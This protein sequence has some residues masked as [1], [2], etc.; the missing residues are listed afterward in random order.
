[1]KFLTNYS[2]CDLK[3]NKCRIIT[4]KSSVFLNQYYKNFGTYDS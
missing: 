3:K 4:P 2:I 1:M